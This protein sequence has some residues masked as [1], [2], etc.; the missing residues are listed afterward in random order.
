[1]ARPK[2]KAPAR[3]FHLSGQSVVTIGRR[4]FYLGPHDSP[5]S[6]A[7]YAVLIGIYQANGL[8]L[9]EEFD[10]AMLDV[11][12][13]TL[14]GQL[15]P[16]VAA[17]DQSKQPTLVRHVTAA[18][19]AHIESKYAQSPTELDRLNLLCDDIDLHDGDV[20]AT[21]YGP[22]RLQAQRQRWID[23]GKARVYCNRLT[24]SVKK[25]SGNLDATR[26][27]GLQFGVNR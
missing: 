18:Y 6:I 13:A 22:L 11:Q 9:P 15:S 10:P 20:T 2:S 24:N 26:W 19:H 12:A 4:D 5:E 27:S 25:A 1:M 21:D 3:R 14:L 7:R 8:T 16:Q 23:S 17:T